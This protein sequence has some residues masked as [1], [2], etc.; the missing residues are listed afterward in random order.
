MQRTLALKIQDSQR[1]LL[2]LNHYPSSQIINKRVKI[3]S[4]WS[5]ECPLQED[6]GSV[7]LGISGSVRMIMKQFVR[8]DAKK[9]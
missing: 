7:E 3:I 9:E 6:P 4:S 2:N 1:T 8:L 5:N